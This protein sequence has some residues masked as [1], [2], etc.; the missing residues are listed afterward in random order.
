MAKKPKTKEEMKNDPIEKMKQTQLERKM[1][2]KQFI[3][4]FAT[5]KEDL[6]EDI[7]ENEGVDI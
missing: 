2:Q 3:D 7:F 1:V 5:G 4:D 6:K